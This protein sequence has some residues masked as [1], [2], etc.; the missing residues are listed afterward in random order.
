M[1]AVRASAV[2]EVLALYEHY[3]QN[4][5]DESLSQLAHALQTAALAE[6]AGAPDPLVAA[7]LLHDVGHL[8]HLSGAA[9]AAGRAHEAT[10]AAYLADLFPASVTAPVA[11]HVRAKQ[12]LCAVDRGYQAL[13]SEGSVRSLQVQGGPMPV[14]EVPAF[15]A[16]PGFADAV[17][18]RRWDDQGKVDGLE[19]PPLA[20]YRPLLDR[21]AASADR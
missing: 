6:E 13:L 3:G 4:H 9:E 7:A 10:G 17:A 5:Y 15:E 16:N 1:S 21:L 11:L 12:Y 8:L 18:L 19:V 2:A 14:A 20:H